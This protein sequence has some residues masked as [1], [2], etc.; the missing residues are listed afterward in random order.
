MTYGERL[1][2]AM[3][4]RGEAL[5][6]EIERKDVAAVAGCSVQNIGMIL[7][8]AKGADQTLSAR[9]HAKV[10][11]LLKVNPDWLLDEVG[12]MEAPSLINAAPALTQALEQILKSIGD[13]APLLKDVGQSTLVKLI[14]GDASISE[15]VSTLD[16]LT[17]ASKVMPKALAV[18]ET[19]VT[20]KIRDE[21]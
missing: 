7:A 10:A 18:S 13:L 3:I 21:N 4:R 1:H 9:S 6:R 2:L 20:Q 11:A 16:A 15:T 5:G 8:N 14:Q 12:T 19:P 17:K